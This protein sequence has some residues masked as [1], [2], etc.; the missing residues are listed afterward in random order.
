ML[1]FPRL[2]SLLLFQQKRAAG[3][4]V[5]KKKR[6]YARFF[7]LFFL[8]SFD[9]GDEDCWFLAHDKGLFFALVFRTCKKKKKGRSKKKKRIRNREFTLAILYE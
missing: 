6:K 9:V 2:F 7:P 3:L 8:F 1:V 5:K 4:C